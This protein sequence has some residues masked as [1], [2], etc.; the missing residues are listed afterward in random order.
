[1]K[2]ADIVTCYI[3]FQKAEFNCRRILGPFLWKWKLLILAKKLWNRYETGCYAITA[4]IWLLSYRG[5]SARISYALHPVCYFFLFILGAMRVLVVRDSSVLC[6]ISVR[7]QQHIYMVLHMLRF[8][9]KR[10]ENKMKAWARK[11]EGN[12]ERNKAKAILEEEYFLRRGC[13]VH[14]VHVWVQN[15]LLWMG[16]KNSHSRFNCLVLL[17]RTQRKHMH[18]PQPGS[19]PHIDLYSNIFMISQ[20]TAYSL[21]KWFSNFA[22]NRDTVWLEEG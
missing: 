21:S 16:K 19:Q 7:V 6:H 20:R 11:S 4:Q 15:K 9:W 1:M 8:T 14:V 12:I 22:I 5:F 3:P 10:N 2:R 13:F 17:T 18:Q